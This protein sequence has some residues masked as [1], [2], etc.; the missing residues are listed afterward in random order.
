MCKCQ[1][2]YKI[3][4]C[5]EKNP[6]CSR[7]KDSIC[8]KMKISLKNKLGNIYSPVEFS[9]ALVQCPIREFARKCTS[10]TKPR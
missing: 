2:K 8:K 3:K 4:K 10:V 9:S 1:N 7:K 5:K 6:N